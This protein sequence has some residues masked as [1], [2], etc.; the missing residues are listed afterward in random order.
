MKGEQGR[1]GGSRSDHSACLGSASHRV[2]PLSFDS[3]E[4]LHK[5]ILEHRKFWDSSQDLQ[6]AFFLLESTT[7][8]T[9]E[10]QGRG[11]GR[12]EKQRSE[13]DPEQL[14]SQADLS[15]SVSHSEFLFLFAFV[16]LSPSQTH[17]QDYRRACRARART[18]TCVHMHVR[19]ADLMTSGFWPSLCHSWDTS[20]VDR[21]ASL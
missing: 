19:G 15:P 12:N 1:D 8:A 21:Y 16:T 7:A 9:A 14:K 11:S 10:K 20:A 3:L 5:C 13:V 17:T 18:R 6:K 4:C 2:K